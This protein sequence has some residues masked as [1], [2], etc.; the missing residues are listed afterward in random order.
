MLLAVLKSAEH[1]FALTTNGDLYCWGLGFKG[2]LGLGDFENRL[3]P[4]MVQNVSCSF[5]ES[6]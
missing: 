6:G 3:R 1:T 5:Y 2:Q 4:T